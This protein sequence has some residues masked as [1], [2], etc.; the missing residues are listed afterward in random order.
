MEKYVLIALS[1]FA[2]WPTLF[3]FGL[4]LFRFPIKPYILQIAIATLMLSQVSI[5]L[6]SA[7]LVY[8]M[9]FTQFTVGTLAIWLI[10]RM[11][12]IYAFIMMLFSFLLLSIIEFTTNGLVPHTFIDFV[13]EHNSYLFFWSG[14]FYCG[15]Q[16]LFT[17]LLHVTR[18]GFTVIPKSKKPQRFAFVGSQAL[19]I[20][21]IIAVLIIISNSL[22]YYIYPKGLVASSLVMIVILVVMLRKFFRWEM[23]E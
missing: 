2:F 15:V 1:Y 23:D 19:K 3:C 20:S 13:N 22:L 16:C 7:H 14:L 5:M 18:F 11:P 4:K 10:F 17:V 6:Q 8:Y 12:F 21:S 9:A